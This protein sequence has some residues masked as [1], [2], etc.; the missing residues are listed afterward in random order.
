MVFSV[1][2][3]SRPHIDIAVRIYTFANVTSFLPGG[4]PCQGWPAARLSG[5]HDDSS[6]GDE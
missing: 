4:D 6:D 1:R 2:A 5:R 3:I